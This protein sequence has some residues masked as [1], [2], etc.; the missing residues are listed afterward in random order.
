MQVMGLEGEGGFGLGSFGSRGVTS[1]WFCDLGVLGLGVL[2]LDCFWVLVVQGPGFRNFCMS[3]FG[4][5]HTKSGFSMS[6]YHYR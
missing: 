6:L 2:G 1:W 4:Y 5:M 3:G